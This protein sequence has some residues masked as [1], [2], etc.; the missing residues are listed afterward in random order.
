MSTPSGLELGNRVILITGAAQGIGEAIAK[1]CAAEGAKVVVTDIPS[2]DQE[3]QAVVKAI[4]DAGGTAMWLPMNIVDEA[5][6]ATV[7]QKV[8][9]TWGGIWGLVNNAGVVGTASS[10][11]NT[12][13]RDFQSQ[14]DINFFGSV[15]VAKAVLPVMK[16]GGGGSIVQMCSAGALWSIPER[17]AYCVSK[18]ATRSLAIQIAAE[19]AVD[20]IRCNAVH[21]G[22]VGTAA[23]LARASM[24]PQQQRLMLAPQDSG[25][26]ISPEAVALQVC[27]VLSPLMEG[28]TGEDITIMDGAANQY[29]PSWRAF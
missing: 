22:R 1:R 27:L 19:H 24:G 4:T 10:V 14:L 17:A 23:A 9:Q 29:R 15:I 6:V 18:A 8:V 13:L 7:V 3:G 12:S 11:L 16:A 5:M 20:N 26:M 28:L 25:K 2:K 21:P